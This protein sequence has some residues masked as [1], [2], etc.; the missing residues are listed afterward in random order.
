MR[1][2]ALFSLLVAVTSSLISCVTVGH[3]PVLTVELFD[4]T[5]R[6]IVPEDMTNR[7]TH[8]PAPLAPDA[9]SVV[10][11]SSADGGSFVA[12]AAARPLLEPQIPALSLSE[13]S[14]GQAAPL[15]ETGLA[16][17]ARTRAAVPFRLAAPVAPGATVSRTAPAIKKVPP[18]PSAPGKQVSPQ[19][20]TSSPGPSKETSAAGTVPTLA[21]ALPTSAGQGGAAS[22]AGDSY[23]RLREIYARQGDEVQIGLDGTGF[24]FLGFPDRAPQA[25]GMSFKGKENRNSKTWFSFQALKLGTYDL[26]FLKQD[27]STGKSIKETVRVHVVSDQEF[28]A[29]MNPPSAQD[30]AAGTVE[31]GDPTFAARLSGVGAFESAISELLK[32]YKDGNP[33][34]NDQIAS[35]YMRTGDYDAASKYFL[36]NISPQNPF[37]PAAV[38]GMVRVAIAQKDQQLLMTYLKQFLALN[39]PSI[40]ETLI[41]AMRMEREKGETGFALDL[42][43]EYS[44]RY[45]GGTWRDEAVFLTAQLLEAD[46]RF[47]DIARARELYRQIA[48]GSPESEYA[49]A[50]RE[51]LLYIER[52]FF[53]V[54]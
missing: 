36:K 39:T 43:K 19:P 6:R 50:A 46:S 14:G 33:A 13:K 53:E 5:A 45:P 35:L 40:E 24:L 16:A 42:A 26:D 7:V 15:V 44:V 22:A 54:R 20:A 49:S 37:T 52:H 25:D 47:R 51:R 1:R 21:S 48:L 38:L 30:P 23:G 8:Y 3:R 18:A 28:N 29:A 12:Q 17:V 10:S 9:R 27:N 31:L 2:R 32:G 4:S 11:D 34:L 41:R